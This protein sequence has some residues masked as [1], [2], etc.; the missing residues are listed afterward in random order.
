MRAAVKGLVIFLIFM[1]PAMREPAAAGPPP[2][3]AGQCRV[4]V[5]PLA[6]GTYQVF[7]LSDRVAVGRLAYHCTASMPV[8]IALF[9]GTSPPKLKG[10]SSE[11]DYEICLDPTCT[12]LWGDG[13]GGTQ[14][15][16]D[17]S[18]P[19]N[20]PVTVYLYGRVPALQDLP[21]GAYAATVT[22]TISW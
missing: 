4:E 1:N 13:S 17:P 11:A 18:P 21:A 14:T 22:A 6:F 10:N 12:A 5:S 15:Y 20:R 2:P 7:A 19:T 16:F 3:G 8:R 9:Y